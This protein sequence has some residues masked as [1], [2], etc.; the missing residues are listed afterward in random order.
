[1]D[2]FVN[3]LFICLVALFAVSSVSAA[4][5]DTDI[6]MSSNYQISS[7]TSN[8]DIQLILDNAQDGDTFE[9]T[10]KEYK[11]ISLVVDRKVNIISKEK[12]VIYTSNQISD[13]AEIE[14]N[15]KEELFNFFN[16]EF[17]KYFFCII[18]K[19]FMINL[20]NILIENYQK[21]LKENEKMTKIINEKAEN[22]LKYV[23]QQLKEKL[24]KELDKYFPQVEESE[25]N[26]VDEIK[27]N[28]NFDY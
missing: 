27:N 9:F 25:T 17:F 26:D 19:L 14:K 15:F 18:I 2:K 21:E 7:D 3:I 5:N 6:I 24:L 8:D 23:T 22:S 16:N 13:E 10:D 1:M 28:F 11:N 12:S 4:D 20:K